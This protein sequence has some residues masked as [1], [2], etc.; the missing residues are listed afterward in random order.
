MA[1]CITGVALLGA[2]SSGALG[3]ATTVSLGAPLAQL[4]APNAAFVPPAGQPWTRAEV[5]T[6][7]AGWTFASPG[8]G[9]IVQA[10]FFFEISTGS[11]TVRV[12]AVNPTTRVVAASSGDLL[13]GSTPQ[14]T[15]S[16]VTSVP[17]AAGEVPGLAGNGAFQ[18]RTSNDG[19]ASSVTLTGTSGTPA[20]GSALTQ[21]SGGSTL[22]QARYTVALAPAATTAP[23]IAGGSAPVAGTPLSGSL[24]TW[25]SSPTGYS[26]EWVRCSASGAACVAIAGATGATY[27]PTA[28][29][30]GYTLRYRVTASN[31][32]GGASDPVDSAATGVV[33]S[34]VFPPPPA[35][36][37][38]VTTALFL[39]PNDPPQPKVTICHATAS[40]SNPYVVITV[41]P[42]AVITK[43]HDQHQDR[44][45]IIPPFDYVKSGK[46]LTYAGLNWDARGRAIYAAGCAT[47]QSAPQQQI[48]DPP[49]ASKVTICHA[50]ASASNPY[51]EITVAP[52]AIFR[53]GHDQHQD[54]R[55]IIPPFSYEGGSYPGLNWDS[56]GR[57]ILGNSCQEPAPV[58][59]PLED[60]AGKVTLCHRVG[61]P[62]YVRITVAPQGAL[63]GHG[64]KHSLDIIPP[65]TYRQ[66]RRE[67]TFPGQNWDAAGRATW[68]NGCVAPPSPE[69]IR[70]EVTCIAPQ[71]DGTYIAYFAYTSENTGSRSIPVGAS[72]LIVTDALSTLSA[73]TGQPT[74]FAPGRVDAQVAVSGIVQAGTASWTI[75]YDGVTTTATATSSSPRCPAPAQET[76]EVG[77]FVQCVT[78]AADGTYSATFG[79]QNDGVNPVSAPIGPANSVAL[80]G[81]AAGPQDR[82]QPTSF[83]PGRTT[84]AFT[85]AGIP[86]G[87]GITWTVDLAS[88]A[89]QAYASWASPRCAGSPEEALPIGVSVT[90][91]QP[92]GDGT[93][94]VVFGYANPNGVSVEVPAGPGNAVSVNPSGPGPESRG[95]PI[96]FQPGSNAD[97]FAVT[98]VPM[99]QEVTWTVAYNGTASVT[100]GSAMSPRCRPDTPDPK[101]RTPD[102]ITP[103]L[104]PL[105]V[106]VECVQANART[107]DA[108]FGYVN[109]SSVP[110]SVQVGD[111]NSVTG[112]PDRGQPSTF[113]PGSVGAAFTVRGIPRRS[114]VTWR[115]VGP[116]GREATATSSA[117][118]VNCQVGIP[119]DGPEILVDVDPPTDPRPPR[120]GPPGIVV[121][122]P[123]TTPDERPEVIVP[124]VPGVVVTSSTPGVSC[125][126]SAARIRCRSA[127]PLLPGRS[128]GLR[129]SG[130]RCSS[131][132]RVLGA[133][134]VVGR[135][136]PG[137]V[138]GSSSARTRLGGC[139]APVTG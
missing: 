70:P 2:G 64:S 137:S 95:Q 25:D 116:D 106:Y 102:T 63:N 5:S 75:T 39:A 3:A 121:D 31:V 6:S 111:A 41:A 60:P 104:L 135:P 29:D 51:V 18:V 78:P 50:T 107:Y 24:G 103:E 134:V 36:A 49:P 85:V 131:A 92:N 99:G 90:C 45:D 58:V 81:P 101:P 40:A 19:S 115:V 109:P 97:A 132:S 9:N 130:R 21:V 108:T 122:N 16:F 84:G 48:L 118:G 38:A 74:S 119:P 129:V 87:A 23:S 83:T 56:A 126:V 7:V 1:A 13:V 14:Q 47:P 114:A 71:A 52:D 80:S 22:L 82:G 133:V 28:A 37:P 12:L 86:R 88:G 43:G 46:T 61:G 91:V 10:S 127:R 125:R 35:S 44:R 15:Q 98:S 8:K 110:V 26:A 136:G 34:G 138:A 105:G 120:S 27:V 139:A 57:E 33:V 100:A 4:G 55:D 54:R 32:E 65:F 128:I 66:G 20:V 11:S 17:I 93:Y 112:G 123:G 62:Q 68:S 30:A 79:Y 76:P 117:S 69:P 94:D 59:D 96:M 53:Q 77:V 67:V 72:N 73:V 113:S 124:R 89:R 42:E